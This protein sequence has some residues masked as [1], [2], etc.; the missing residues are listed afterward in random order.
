MVTTHFME[1]A[2]YCDRVAIIAEG[3]LV[4]IGSPAELRARARSDKVPEPTLD[5]AF[6]ALVA[7]GL[8]RAA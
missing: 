4:A 1:E 8:A 7:P 3:R 5:D 6:V 2:E